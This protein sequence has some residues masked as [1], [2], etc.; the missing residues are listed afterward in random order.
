MSARKRP[1]HSISF[2]LAILAAFC[3]WNTASYAADPIV[4]N[5]TAMQRPG[6]NLVDITYDLAW[7]HGRGSVRG[8]NPRE[9]SYALTDPGAVP[10][11]GFR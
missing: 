5:L 6:T 4:S 3:V 9:E 10:V 1:W 2:A 7:L 8:V 11:G